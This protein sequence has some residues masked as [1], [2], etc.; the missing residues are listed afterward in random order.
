[1]LKLQTALG[2]YI[3]LIIAD[4]MRYIYSGPRVLCRVRVEFFTNEKSFKERLQIYTSSKIS[5]PP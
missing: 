2:I 5:E 3:A 1:L 4:V